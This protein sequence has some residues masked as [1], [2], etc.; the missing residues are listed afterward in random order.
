[1]TPPIEP[2]EE[3]V[4]A[5]LMGDHVTLYASIA[6]AIKHAHESAAAHRV[7]SLMLCQQI[8]T[9]TDKLYVLKERQPQNVLIN[10][11]IDIG[12]VR[13]AENPPA[14]PLD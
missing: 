2:T 10:F 12:G 9:A 13:F 11:I 6:W 7:A 8:T 14:S 4:K 5:A 3:S 1:M